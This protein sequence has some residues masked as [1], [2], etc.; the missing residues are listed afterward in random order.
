MMLIFLFILATLPTTV[1]TFT[2]AVSSPPR[3]IITP[4]DYNESLVDYPDREIIMRGEQCARLDGLCDIDELEILVD[5]LE[6]FQ[7]SDMHLFDTLYHEDYTYI[8]KDG[9]ISTKFE[10][11]DHTHTK[12]L[13]I[14][15]MQI[16]KKHKCTTKG[17][18][19]IDGKEKKK[20][21]VAYDE[22][23]SLPSVPKHLRRDDEEKRIYE[24]YQQY[25][26]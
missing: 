14:L 8:T 12:V 20:T 5:E 23:L 16:M 7:S 25:Q 1:Q 2:L 21:N 10:G 17:K 26:W 22:Y 4:P 13:E 15:Q 24:Y 6:K 18:G 9:S 3:A 19:E 11:V